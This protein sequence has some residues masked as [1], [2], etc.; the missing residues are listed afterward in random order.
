MHTFFHG[1]RVTAVLLALISVGCDSPSPPVKIIH[2]F[3]RQWVPKDSFAV[4]LRQSEPTL[5]D[6][7]ID[8]R[9]ATF[10]DD[11]EELQNEQSFNL[12]QLVRTHGLRSVF[13]EGVTDDDRESFETE[14]GRIEVTE[15]LQKKM[16]DYDNS[17]EAMRIRQ[18]LN[19]LYVEMREERIQLGAVGAILREGAIDTVMPLEAADPVTV[20]GKIR[21]D[22][23]TMK[24]REAEMARRIVAGGPV[25]I[26]VLGGEHDLTDA[27]KAT[28]R[29][30]TYERI[31]LPTY[32]R[33]AK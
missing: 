16:D 18:N 24:A 6:G 21:S 30:F 27:L 20:D 28:G 25:A 15:K 29:P 8:D 14:N 2:V 26:V 19:R 32:T 33:L 10:L 9:Y 31:E 5:T 17:V 11:V 4:D 1:W 23:A 3:N 22:S 7:Q 12:R 13:Y